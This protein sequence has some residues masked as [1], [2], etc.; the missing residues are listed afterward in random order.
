MKPLTSACQ[1]GRRL[2]NA[3]G[4][5]RKIVYFTWYSRDVVQ[6]VLFR[7]LRST[8]WLFAL[9]V[10]EGILRSPKNPGRSTRSTLRFRR[11]G[12]SHFSTKEMRERVF[13]EPAV[14]RFIRVKEKRMLA[15]WSQ[16]PKRYWCLRLSEATRDLWE[17]A[18]LT[19]DPQIPPNYVPLPIMHALST[20]L[21]VLWHRHE[22]RRCISSLGR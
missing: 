20:H 21:M 3:M 13:R 11:Y 16:I 4:A 14:Y 2:S 9:S 7:V 15:D 8:R 6:N 5:K 22:V 1:F 18:F 12:G 17:L 10:L 19:P